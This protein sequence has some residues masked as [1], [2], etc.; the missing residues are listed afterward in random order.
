MSTTAS[1]LATP[2]VASQAS[3]LVMRVIGACAL[4]HL[5]N[6]L[7][8]AVLPSIYPVLKANYGLSFT[9][10]GLITL[11]FQLTASLLQPWVGYHTDRHPKPWL[12]PLGSVCTLI[13][14]LMLAFVGSFHAILL[15]SAL[16]GIGSSTFH[17]ETSR[18][19]RL[20]SGGRYGLAQSTFQVGGNAGSA[21]GPLLAAA[22]IIPYGQGNVAYFGLF[23]VFL[24][25]VLW[26]LSRW[27]SHHLNLFKLKAGGVATHGLSKGR[28]TASLVVLALLVFSKYFYMASFTSYYTF[29]LIEKFDLSVASSQLYLF[30]FL[31]A[32]A[33]GTFF[34]GPVGD[35]IGRKAVIWFSI[36]GVTPFT[37]ALPYVDLFWTSIL[38]LVIGFILASAFSAIVVYAQE[39]VPGNVGMIAGVFFG[40][41][42]GFG[43]IGAAFLG[44]LADIHGIEYVY[45]LCSYLPLLGCL[46][47]L[48]PS[49]KK[50]A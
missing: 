44:H 12:A 23:A 32:V 14:I 2:S 33:A 8:Q 4:A 25:G 49:T 29:Y 26:G 20:A 34:G 17:P 37:L 47:I 50:K 16:V 41:M 6:D 45:T 43:G 7:I 48:L 9:Q 42:F 5:T 15:A 46:T 3:P 31:G 19:A 18:I 24:V 27:Y 21:F 1:P 40:L 38:S 39:L 11:T 30:G 22:I 28:V 10:V 35:R 13:G 36:L